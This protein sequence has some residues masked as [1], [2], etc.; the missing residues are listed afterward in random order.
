MLAVYN[1][2]YFILQNGENQIFAPGQFFF[3]CT[4]HNDPLHLDLTHI[5]TVVLSLQLI[6]GWREDFASKYIAFPLHKN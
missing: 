5:M 6:S 2:K 4:F 1:I 3:K